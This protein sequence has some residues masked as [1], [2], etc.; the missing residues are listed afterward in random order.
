MSMVTMSCRGTLLVQL[1]RLRS[2]PLMAGL[3][4]LAA[5]LVAS[6]GASAAITFVKDIGTNK[7]ATAGTTIG[8]TV[9]V[10]GV[11]A[12]N[13]IVLTLAM[14]DAAGT[15]SATDSSSNSYT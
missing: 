13:T 4:I 3:V 7:T 8:V 1:S 11:A 10:A 12:G 5:L 6:T 9:P 14:G 15:V 2:R